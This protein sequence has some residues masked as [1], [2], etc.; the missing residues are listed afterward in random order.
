MRWEEE[1]KMVKVPRVTKGECG[2]SERAG[3]ME[4]CTVVMRKR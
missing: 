3:E 1:K 4:C 2:C